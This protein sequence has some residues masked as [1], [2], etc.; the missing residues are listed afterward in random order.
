MIGGFRRGGR[1][2]SWPLD[3]RDA[4]VQKRQNLPIALSSFTGNDSRAPNSGLNR[5]IYPR[6]T[7][8]PQIQT[9]MADARMPILWRIQAPDGN[10]TRW[11]R[12]LRWDYTGKMPQIPDRMQGLRSKRAKSLLPPRGSQSLESEELMSKKNASVSWQQL[13]HICRHERGWRGCGRDWPRHYACTPKNCP[14]WKRWI[15]RVVIEEK[16]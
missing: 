5:T 9:C 2:C 12:G 10:D 14:V 7:Y 6:Q 13:R 4:I 11:C 1:R 16:E 15:K 3:G 8:D